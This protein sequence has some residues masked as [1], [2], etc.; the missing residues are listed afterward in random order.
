MKIRII[1][2]LYKGRWIKAPKT[3]KTRPTSS[4]LR[5]AFFNICQRDIADSSFL[6]LFAGSGAMGIEAISREAKKSTFVEK[7]K[8]ALFA[9]KENTS[10]LEIEEQTK[11]YPL[12]ILKALDL[13]LKNNETFDLIYCDPPYTLSL[14]LLE[15][16]VEKAVMLLNKNG[17]MF[18]EFG[19]DLKNFSVEPVSMKKFSDT[20]LLEFN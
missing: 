5:E 16:V 7:E 10:S 14:D 20:Y 8:Q 18:L 12:D 11:V 17:K 15:K 9:I 6:D 3:S 4:K 2:G 1:S 19:Q 13:L